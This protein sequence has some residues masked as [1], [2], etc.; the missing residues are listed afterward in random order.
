MKDFFFRKFASGGDAVVAACDAELAGKVLEDAKA[1]L[2]VSKLFYCDRMCDERELI[3]VM[4]SSTI[5]NLAG[6][7]CVTV[8]VENGMV[9]KESVLVI[10][11]VMHAQAVTLQ[12]NC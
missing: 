5:M 12:K 6:N 9:D 3:E 11:G 2:S 4:R 1:R 10:D 7:R 8:A